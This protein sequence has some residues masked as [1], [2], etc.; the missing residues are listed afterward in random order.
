MEIPLSRVPELFFDKQLWG[1]FV[2]YFDSAENAYESIGFPPGPTGYFRD[3]N[4]SQI[5]MDRWREI[6]EVKH[7]AVDILLCLQRKLLNGEL[8]ASGVPAARWRAT[9]EP[10]P[11]SYW[12]RLWPNFFGNWA[13]STQERYDDI[14]VSWTPKNEKV[15]LQERLEEFLNEQKRRGRDARKILLAAAGEY[16]GQS[17]PARLFNEG[18]SKVFN[19]PRGRPRS[20]RK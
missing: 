15:E 6:E 18:Y 19:K 20:K 3:D 10:I 13:M 1:I 5:T 4:P 17:I 2:S 9:R 11:P 8:V 14:L 7:V 16:F 12:L